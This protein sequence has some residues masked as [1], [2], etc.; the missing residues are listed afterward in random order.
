MSRFKYEDWLAHF[1]PNHDP[2]TGRFAKSGIG[3]AIERHRLNKTKSDD[4]KRSRELSKRNPKS[5]T[6][7]EL[8]YVAERRELEKKATGHDPVKDAAKAEMAR[9]AVKTIASAAVITA[10]AVGAHYL[11]KKNGITLDKITSKVL[12]GAGNVTATITKETAAAATKAVKDA[13]PTVKDTAESVAK[14]ATKIAG[15]ALDAVGTAGNKALGTAANAVAE[16]AKAATKT[17]AE[18]AKTAAKSATKA[19]GDAL[20]T[21]GTA[22][23]KALGTAAKTVKGGVT[24]AIDAGSKT[25]VIGALADATTKVEDISQQAVEK[26]KELLKKIGL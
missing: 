24:K 26:G 7:E 6:N 2:S 20:D 3:R 13:M 8:R 10:A 4:Y 22:G 23:N 1:N 19:A 5:L 12:K 9:F 21:V 14:S 15:D 18:G 11:I 25:K 17:V 16:G